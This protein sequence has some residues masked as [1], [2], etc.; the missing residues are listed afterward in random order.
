M[1]LK[2][3]EHLERN[4]IHN[5]FSASTNPGLKLVLTLLILLASFL[6]ASSIFFVRNKTPHAQTNVPKSLY[7]MHILG[8]F[9]V[10]T[11][12]KATKAAAEGIQVVFDYGQPPSESDQ[13]GQELQALHMKV[14]DGYISS[15]LFYYECH[16]T[17]TVKPPPSGQ[18]PF[19]QD[20][21]YPN[22]KDE[23]ALLA[24]IS[25]H[26]KQVQE[27]HLIIGYW[28]LDDWVPWDAGSARQLLIAIH[29]LIRQYTP[30]RPSICGFGGNIGG[31]KQNDGW[32]DWV[33]DNFS[34]Q[35]CDEVG[36]Y[37]YAPSLLNT[38]SA[39]PIGFYDWS[40]LALLPAMD[41]SLQRRG[42]EIEKEPLI[43]IGQA[44]GGPIAQT[45]RYWVTPTAKDIE[46]QSRSFCEHGAAG[47]VFYAWNNSEFGPTA[48][49]PMNNTGIETGIRNGIAA[50]KLFWSKRTKKI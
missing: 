16:R 12:E 39:P 9:S 46:T 40:M 49:T 10:D 29:H 8:G 23:H 34:P 44:F 18:A 21:L 32:S 11:P 45:D 6:L 19:C 47:L 41:A 24:T 43:G 13:V 14:V 17:K 27:N 15:Y 38:A 50:C 31:P 5:A 42:W 20:D 1:P 28:V 33:A 25:A 35:G 22:L 4:R 3:T 48:Q 36:F 7:N 2:L 26:L 37:V 30:D